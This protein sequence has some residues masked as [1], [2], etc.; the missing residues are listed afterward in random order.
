MGKKTEKKKSLPALAYKI[1]KLAATGYQGRL[2]VVEIGPDGERLI[3]R[4]HTKE[5]ALW[6]RD[7]MEDAVT[8]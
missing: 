2:G 8:A 6:V 4:Y 7:A 3:A 5:T 1:R